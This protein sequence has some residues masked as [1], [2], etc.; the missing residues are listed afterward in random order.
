MLP[1]PLRLKDDRS[2]TAA[3]ARSPEMFTVSYKAS[4]GTVCCK[5]GL[6]SIALTKFICAITGEAGDDIVVERSRGGQLGMMFR[7]DFD[8]SS[9]SCPLPNSWAN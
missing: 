9:L 7:L 8:A 2:R 5:T 1:A 6:P 3:D 4:D